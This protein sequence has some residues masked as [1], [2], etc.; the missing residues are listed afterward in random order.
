M[1]VWIV[2]KQKVSVV[3]EKMLVMAILILVV[4]SRNAH[5]E[6]RVLQLSGGMSFVGRDIGTLGVSTNG[7][8]IEDGVNEAHFRKLGPP[9][10]SMGHFYIWPLNESRWVLGWYI[11]VP[12]WPSGTSY[13]QTPQWR[14]RKFARFYADGGQKDAPPSSGWC[15]NGKDGYPILQSPILHCD[16]VD[17]RVEQ[18]PS[19]ISTTPNQTLAERGSFTTEGTVLCEVDN[20]LEYVENT[21]VYLKSDRVCDKSF[22]C[23]NQMD[24]RACFENPNRTQ[25]I[26][27]KGVGQGL[28]GVY[29]LQ[30]W[31]SI[32]FYARI[33]KGG[34]VYQPS[35]EQQGPVIGSGEGSFWM[36]TAIYR[37]EGKTFWRSVGDGRLA[38]EVQLIPIPDAFKKG[39]LENQTHFEK[40]ETIPGVGVICLSPQKQEK[41]FIAFNDTAAGW[42]DKTWHCQF[43]GV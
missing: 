38:S 9:H 40:E 36:A 3:I 33:G 34:F 27:L 14:R 15:Q 24:E 43:G 37:S 19:L 41:M 11:R 4:S 1:Y 20:M 5:G 29:L 39:L 22:D 7:Y 35:D 31:P 32:E 28:A 6:T 10:P 21:W 8:Y 42:C 2:T 26:I 18:L 23:Y 30:Q 17:M 12:L 16:P 13:E 25:A